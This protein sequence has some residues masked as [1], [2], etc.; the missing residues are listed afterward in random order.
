VVFKPDGP[1]SY[2]RT[3]SS[4]DQGYRQRMRGEVEAADG[5]CDG[6]EDLLDFGEIPLPPARWQH[7]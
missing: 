2:D 1:A 3:G 7:T 5:H 6:I 4:S